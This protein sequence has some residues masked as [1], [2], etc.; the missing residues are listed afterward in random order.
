MLGRR[1][2]R[3]QTALPYYLDRGPS[4]APAARFSPMGSSA[5]ASVHPRAWPSRASHRYRCAVS[6]MAA[7]GLAGEPTTR[8]PPHAA[9]C[10]W[11]KFAA[12][13]GQTCT[14]GQGASLHSLSRWTNAAIPIVDESR[15]R[16][17]CVAVWFRSSTLANRKLT[18]LA[19]LHTMCCG[20]CA[21]RS[22]ALLVQ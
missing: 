1:W 11:R 10:D 4:V 18:R 22:S 21:Q 6:V 13:T 17:M 7:L 5:L 15:A 20:T 8:A 12:M 2:H 3:A 14:A 9:A 16:W 19:D